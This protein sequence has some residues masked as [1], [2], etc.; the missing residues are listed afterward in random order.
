MNEGYGDKAMKSNLAASI[1]RALVYAQVLLCF[2]GAAT[3]FMRD[4]DHPQSVASGTSVP[5]SAEG[6]VPL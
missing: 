4:H 5:A 1:L 6:G 2:A 3:V